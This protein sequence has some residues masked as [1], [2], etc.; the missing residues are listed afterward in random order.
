MI[1]LALETITFTFLTHLPTF[2]LL[3]SFYNVK[4]STALASYAI[5]LFSTGFPL[6]LLRKARSNNGQTKPTVSLLTD[7]PTTIYTT[8]AAASVFSLVLYT[9]YATWLPAQL[10]THF[11]NIRDIS[12]THAGPAG[13]PILFTC[14]IPAGWA[15]RNF[16]FAA[17]ARAAVTADEMGQKGKEY[18]D[19]DGEYLICVLYRKTWGAL[20]A[21][22]RVL[23]VRTVILTL[24]TLAN[25]VVQLV[26][27]VKGV[28]VEGAVAWG[29]VWAVSGLLVGLV[30]GW[31]GGGYAVA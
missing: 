4:P 31:I 9:S 20:A 24:M 15:A 5:I 14:L 11:S 25:T 22:T 8:L 3:T 6:V 23:I 13:W 26:G 2:T 18:I 17:W 16:L 29:A 19:R 27:T 30:F 7:P 21:C 28:S 10:V 1:I 12:A